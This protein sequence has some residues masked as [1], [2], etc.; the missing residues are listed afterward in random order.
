[1]SY[2][3]KIKEKNKTVYQQIAEELGTSV[4]YVG[5]IARSERTPSKKKGMEVK[6]RLEELVNEETPKP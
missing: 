6:K 2:A 3:A 4:D 5:K 1:M